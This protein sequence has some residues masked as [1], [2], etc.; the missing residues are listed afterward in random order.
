MLSNDSSDSTYVSLLEWILHSVST[1]Y[2]IQIILKHNLFATYEEMF[3]SVRT[4][5]KKKTHIPLKLPVS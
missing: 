1:G 5:G 2:T 4:S 3:G